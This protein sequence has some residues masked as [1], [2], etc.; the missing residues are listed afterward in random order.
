[1]ASTNYTVLTVTNGIFPSNTYILTDTERGCSIV[2]DPG[3]D[4]AA[5]HETITRHRIQPVAVVAT[6]GHFD[7]IGGVYPLQEQYQAPYYLHESDLKISRSANFYLKLVKLPVKITTP[8]PDHLFKG[9]AETWNI[10]GFTFK[11]YNFPGHTEGSC[12]LQ[13]GDFLFTG[14]ILYKK[15]LGFNSFP[16]ED[17][18]KLRQSITEIFNRFPDNMMVYPG[19]G[20]ASALGTI[21]RENQELRRFL[22]L[23]DETA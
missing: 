16:G 8:V 4:T 7:H 23:N 19:H 5:L 9:Q 6:H 15:G 20:E 3:L 2:I 11:V 18:D 13:A 10:A 22:H 1:M 21:K 14:D 12:V 17:R